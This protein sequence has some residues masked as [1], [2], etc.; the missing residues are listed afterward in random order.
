MGVVLTCY[1]R[2]CNRHCI[3]LSREESHL[4]SFSTTTFTSVFWRDAYREWVSQKQICIHRSLLL[5]SDTVMKAMEDHRIDVILGERLDLSS[6]SPGSVKSNKLGQRVV[7][8]LKGREIAADLLVR[9]ICNFK[10]K[11]IHSH[12]SCCAQGK[13]Q[14]RRSSLH[15]HLPQLT[16]FQSWHM[17]YPHYSSLLDRL[18]L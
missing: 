7:R 10:K 16:Q 6:T 14:T 18:H 11:D 15:C 3:L 13:C 17:F 8:T 2:I 5:L 1:L 12:F 9:P 4:A